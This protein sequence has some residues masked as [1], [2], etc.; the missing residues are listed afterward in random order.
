MSFINFWSFYLIC[1]FYSGSVYSSVV[2]VLAAGGRFTRTM[3]KTRKGNKPG[4]EKKRASVKARCVGAC[5][6]A[7]CKT[8]VQ[9][10][11]AMGG[12][13]PIRLLAVPAPCFVAVTVSGSRAA[14]STMSSEMEEENR[15]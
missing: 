14:G 5:S 4:K 12:G 9:S 2:P 13:G 3:R 8:A 1:L 7:R 10:A 6:S 15:Q 11:W